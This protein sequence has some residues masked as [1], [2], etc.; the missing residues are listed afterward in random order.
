VDDVTAASVRFRG[1][2]V[3]TFAASSLLPA[4]HTAALRT[5]SPGGLVL[6]V[7]EQELVIERDG[8]REVLNPAVDGH[9]AVDREFVDAVLGR[10]ERTRAP[11]AEALATHRVACALA[12][13]AATG[14]PVGVPA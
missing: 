2:A 14:R 4:K 12:E 3:G 8:R 1:G 11:Y 9:E 6:D 10:R 7:S 13:S 5:V